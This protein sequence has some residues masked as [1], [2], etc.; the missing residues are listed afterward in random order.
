MARE[1]LVDAKKTV[2]QGKSPAH[3]KQREKRPVWPPPRISAT[4]PPSV[5]PGPG[6]PTV[7]RR[8][9]R[10]SLIGTCCRP[11]RYCAPHT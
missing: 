11:S 3:E 8:C 10:A 7:P 2:A 6:W 4:W 5:S 9:A 1:K